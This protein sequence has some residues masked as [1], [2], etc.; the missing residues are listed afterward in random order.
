MGQWSTMFKSRNKVRGSCWENQKN[1]T[2]KFILLVSLIVDPYSIP[3]IKAKY[4]K[5]R[6]TTGNVGGA[7]PLTFHVPPRSTWLSKSVY[8]HFGETVG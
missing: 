7:P 2:S 4:S 6:G 5:V 3:Q 8:F 1:K